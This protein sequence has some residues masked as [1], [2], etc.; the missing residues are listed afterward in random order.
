MAEGIH[1]ADHGV[2]WVLLVV[3]ERLVQDFDVGAIDI[4]LVKLDQ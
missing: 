2:D 3:G 4:I 1:Q